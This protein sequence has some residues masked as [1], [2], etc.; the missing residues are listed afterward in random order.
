MTITTIP[1]SVRIE[2]LQ[3]L[4]WT[5]VRRIYEEGLAEIWTNGQWRD[6]LLL[7]RRSRTVGTG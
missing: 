3:P 5:D 2:R 4:H 6:V 7:E 1:S